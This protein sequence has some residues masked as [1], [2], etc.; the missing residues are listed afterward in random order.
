MLSP[1]SPRFEFAR[2]LMGFGEKREIHAERR[3]G[4]FGAGDRLEHEI[5]G[6]AAAHRFHLRGDVGE[7]AAL[8]G[9]AQ[10][11]AQL[12]DQAEKT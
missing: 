11:E 1:I 4:G 8:H 7:H 6:R 12:V 10:R 2:G 5:D 9:N 3:V